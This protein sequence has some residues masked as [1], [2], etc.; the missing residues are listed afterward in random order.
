MWDEVSSPL[1]NFT[2]STYIVLLR[3]TDMMSVAEQELINREVWEMWQCETNLMSGSF[4][5]VLSSVSLEVGRLNIKISSYQYKHSHYNDKTV[6]RPSHV[7]NGKL[8]P[9]KTV[10]ILRRDPGLCLQWRGIPTCISTQKVKGK[11]YESPCFHTAN[12][13]VSERSY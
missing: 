8:I 4:V 9:G 1:P 13:C 10:F 7:Y 5:T 12:I 3:G 6:S 2:P 11:K